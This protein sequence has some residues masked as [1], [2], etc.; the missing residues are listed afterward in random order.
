MMGILREGPTEQSDLLFG[1][2]FNNLQKEL[3]RIED[4][5]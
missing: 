1:T 4:R 5:H 3:I 2:C